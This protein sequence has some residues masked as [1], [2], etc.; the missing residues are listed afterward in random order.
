MLKTWLAE[1]EWGKCTVLLTNQHSCYETIFVTME[2]HTPLKFS[3]T[4][5]Y[6]EH[7]VVHHRHTVWE[8]L[9]GLMLWIWFSL[10]QFSSRYLPNR[11]RQFI[12]ES[13][14]LV[15]DGDTFE[16]WT[17]LLDFPKGNVLCEARH[18]DMLTNFCS[19]CVNCLC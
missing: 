7:V 16:S 13:S 17:A 9:W 11:T 10:L 3:G 2:S 8:L 19:K 1:C 15:I 4:E 18:P 14:P 5:K 12:S 6:S